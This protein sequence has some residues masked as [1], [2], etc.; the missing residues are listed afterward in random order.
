MFS[1]QALQKRN[2]LYSPGLAAAL[3]LSDLK[4]HANEFGLLE[5][6]RFNIERTPNGW[7]T[8]DSPTMWYNNEL[9]LLQPTCGVGYLSRSDRTAR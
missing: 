7:L 2:F 9:Y 4:I 1:Q 8:E 5:G 3:S 6:F